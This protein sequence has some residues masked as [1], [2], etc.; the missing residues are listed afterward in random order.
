ML[1][2]FDD[3]C[4]V[5]GD[6]VGTVCGIAVA[7]IALTLGVSEKVVARA[8]ESGCTTLEEIKN[9]IENL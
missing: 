8:I 5:V 4:D 9:F 7:P 6:V 3:I 2:I 1:G